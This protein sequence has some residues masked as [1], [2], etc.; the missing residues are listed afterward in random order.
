[1]ILSGLVPADELT[2]RMFDEKKWER[3]RFVMKA[4]DEVNRK[5]GRDTLRFGFP[6][7]NA[8]WRGKSEWRSNRYT[9]RFKEIVKVF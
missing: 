3:F 2:E 7:S 4:V 9:T 1:M 8:M 6:T 5:F